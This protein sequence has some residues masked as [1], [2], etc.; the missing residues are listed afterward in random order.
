LAA[1]RQQNTEQKLRVC[2]VQSIRFLSPAMVA[3][4]VI[5][6]FVSVHLLMLPVASNVWMSV[7]NE[8]ESVEGCVVVG[9]DSA[10][11]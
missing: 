2:V 6:L 7:Y 9:S 3:V 5:C 8:F 10:F 4:E 11:A 1:H